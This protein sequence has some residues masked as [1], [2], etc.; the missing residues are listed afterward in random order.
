[1]QIMGELFPR[2]VCH[3]RMVGRRYRAL[4]DDFHLWRT[5]FLRTFPFRVGDK[6]ERN[7]W[8][9]HFINQLSAS[10]ISII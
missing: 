10:A 2:D 7:N 5:L 9:G 6:P 8:K 1:M 4:A 3:L